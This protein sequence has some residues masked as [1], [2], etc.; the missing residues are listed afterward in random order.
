MGYFFLLF[1]ASMS[2]NQTRRCCSADTAARRDAMCTR[3][4][5]LCCEVLAITRSAMKRVEELD[6]A[7]AQ[8]QQRQQQQQ[9]GLQMLPRPRASVVIKKPRVFKAVP[10]GAAARAQSHAA[11]QLRPVLHRKSSDGATAAPSGGTPADAARRITVKYPVKAGAAAAPRRKTRRARRSASHSASTAAAAAAASTTGSAGAD[12]A[13]LTATRNHRMPGSHNDGVH[14]LQHSR[15]TRAA[16]IIESEQ[17][18]SYLNAESGTNFIEDV[19]LVAEDNYQR[20]LIDAQNEQQQHS[21]QQNTC[22]SKDCWKA[23]LYDSSNAASAEHSSVQY[24]SSTRASKVLHEHDSKALRDYEGFV[25]GEGTPAGGGVTLSARCLVES[26]ELPISVEDELSAL[27]APLHTHGCVPSAAALGEAASN[28]T[29]AAAAPPAHSAQLVTTSNYY[30]VVYIHQFTRLRKQSS[31]SSGSRSSTLRRGLTSH[32]AL[33]GHMSPFTG[34]REEEEGEPCMVNSY[35][36]AMY[37]VADESKKGQGPDHSRTNHGDQPITV[38]QTDVIHNAPRLAAA[39]EKNER[40][41]ANSPIADHV[42]V[43]AVVEPVVQVELR[44]PTRRFGCGAHSSGVSS[45]STPAGGGAF[46]FPQEMNMTDSAR[47][48]AG[49]VLRSFPESRGAADTATEGSHEEV[50]AQIESMESWR[51]DRHTSVKQRILRHRNSSFVTPGWHGEYYYY[52]SSSP[53]RASACPMP[54]PP[55]AAATALKMTSV[56][57]DGHPCSAGVSPSNLSDPYSA[58]PAMPQSSDEDMQATPPRRRNTLRTE[59]GSAELCAAGDDEMREL[60]APSPGEAVGSSSDGG[61][62]S[63]RRSRPLSSPSV[64]PWLSRTAATAATPEQAQSPSPARAGSPAT[65]AT[66]TY[67][68]LLQTR[69]SASASS[70]PRTPRAVAATATESNGRHDGER[71]RSGT[72][73]AGKMKATSAAAAGSASCAMP[74]RTHVSPPLQPGSTSTSFSRRRHF[75]RLE[76]V[77]ASDYNTVEW[78]FAGEA[79]RASV[80]SDDPATAAAK[81]TPAELNTAAVDATP[82]TPLWV[83]F[84]RQ[85]LA[86]EEQRRWDAWTRQPHGAHIHA[87]IVLHISQ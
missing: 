46:R 3:I 82:S 69:L 6:V 34:E 48:E 38:E 2:A 19:Q 7:Y 49:E 57:A 59:E 29:T 14:V 23:P 47:R 26:S 52:S 24:P 18:E 13:A 85:A 78:A 37:D 51:R 55:M 39:G 58:G 56:G 16:D 12:V 72:G 31:T 15:Q 8:Q 65:A 81:R 36:S 77:V 75:P 84:Q 1:G 68:V 61:G 67:D 40:Q 53:A 45:A 80:L 63:S 32:L 87:P 41:E 62:G 30:R 11:T 20:I 83:E 50:A 44:V 79:R 33:P 42:P 4:R 25:Y 27:A 22:D 5:K 54:A 17:T 35:V 21:N 28:T 76:V 9:N 71:G 43:V 10:H 64:Q 74:S 86:E 73:T 66:T 60:S 70:T